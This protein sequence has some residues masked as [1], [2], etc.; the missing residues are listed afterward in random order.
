[1]QEEPAD[2][3]D[4]ETL[5]LLASIGIVKGKPFTPDASMKKILTEAAAVGN[6]TA[7]ALTFRPR[8]PA[9][10]Y[11]P[12]SAWYSPFIGAADYHY[13]FVNRGA[14]DLD[15]RVEW[16]YQATGQTPAMV[17][18][19]VG[20]GSQYAIAAV[21][22]RGEY[23]DGSKQYRL[24]LPPNVPA[25]LFWSLL[26]YDTQTRSQLQTDQP[27]PSMNNVTPGVEI[28]ADGSIDVYF[29]P[30]S[31]GAAKNWIQTVPGKSW[32]VWLRL[33]GPLDPWFDKTW[34]PGEIEEVK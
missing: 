28:N 11:Y 14:R 33:Y 7:R 2:A 21:D 17:V 9:Q 10:Y 1:V 24:R 19:A 31:P 13:D 15:A 5:G 25:K 23:L 4:P 16:F 12:N 18:R 29:A 32:F 20:S 22:S 27:F 34:R 8:D 3:Q 6:A 26:V 30:G